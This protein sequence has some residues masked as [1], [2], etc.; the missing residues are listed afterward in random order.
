ML[1]ERAKAFCN[2]A[3]DIASNWSI[4]TGIRHSTHQSY[5]PVTSLDLMHPHPE[6][7]TERYAIVNRNNAMVMSSA[8]HPKKKLLT[9][10]LAYRRLAFPL[11][12]WPTL[13]IR[14]TVIVTVFLPPTV[15]HLPL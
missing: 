15:R 9:S 4:D 14:I 6:P 5:H 3:Y 10:S 13:F 12:W 11:A 8:V 7:F 1:Q 2:N